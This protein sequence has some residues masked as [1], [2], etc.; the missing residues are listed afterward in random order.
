MEREL[1]RT[2]YML[3]LMFDKPWGHWRYSTA[4]VLGVYFWAVVHD[5]PTSWATD[6]IEWPDDLRPTWLPPQST[7]SRR[8]RR[9]EAVELMTAVEQYLVTLLA[10]GQYLVHMIDAKALPV[11]EVSRDPDI[12][13][14]RGTGGFQKGYKFY[15][16]WS[17]GPMPLAWGLA[18]MNVSEKTMA[19]R[20][21]PTLPGGGYL[22]GDPEYD[23]NPLYDLAAEAG[24]QLV[25]KKRRDRGRGGLGHRRQ[26]PG[27]LRSIELLETK[28]GRELF[29]QRNAIECRFGTLTATAGGLAP[30][31][32]WVRHFNRVRNWV[33]AKIVAAGVRWLMIHEPTKLALA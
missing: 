3:A 24:F 4:E 12:G 21:I 16:I 18:P 25:A 10:I 23:A 19:R 5:R 6:P 22:L 31:P 32:A 9:P 30:L 7:M 11:S 28:F 29:N 1:W 2:L 26:S 27:R 17:G 13:R 8:L 14:G 33:Q 20:L 15:A